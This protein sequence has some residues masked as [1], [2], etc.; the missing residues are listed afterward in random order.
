MDKVNDRRLKQDEKKPPTSWVCEPI[1][2]DDEQLKEITKN[3]KFFTPNDGGFAE[4]MK[5]NINDVMK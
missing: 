3:I 1:Q 2:L 5:I 4:P